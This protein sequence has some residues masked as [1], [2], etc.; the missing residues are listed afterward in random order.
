L[1]S[2]LEVGT[3]FFVGY[4]PRKGKTPAIRCYHETIPKVVSGYTK[5][6]LE[7]TKKLYDQIVDQTVP[8]SSPKVAER[9]KILE[10]ITA[11]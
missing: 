5:N 9:T 6:C 8:V 10:N 3:N 7:V 1:K 11:Q 2:R 4:S